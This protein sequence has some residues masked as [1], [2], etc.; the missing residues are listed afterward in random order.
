[1]Q[2]RD[3]PSVDDI[4]IGRK[5]MKILTVCDQGNNRSVQFAHLL[6]YWG[7]DCITAGLKTNSPETL[8]MLFQW[9]DIIITTDDTQQ[10]PEQY[11]AKVKLLDVGPDKYPRPFNP[12]LNAMVKRILEENK[13][14]LKKN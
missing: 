5:Q 14:W 8:D 11:Q 9:A 7:N 10:I 4:A 12:E 6:K 1:L 3:R 13:L 2:N